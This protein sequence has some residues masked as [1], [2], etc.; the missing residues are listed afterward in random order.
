MDAARTLVADLGCTP[1][2]G[3][4]LARAMQLEATAAFMIGLWF[5]GADA[6]AVLP[7]LPSS[8][9]HQPA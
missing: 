6:Q 7:P 5:G 4:G 3:G 8:G 1:V 9:E 2:N